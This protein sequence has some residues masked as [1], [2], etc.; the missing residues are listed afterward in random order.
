MDVF[1]AKLIHIAS[2]NLHIWSHTSSALPRCLQWSH[3]L[4]E[5]S[6]DAE[7]RAHFSL[8]LRQFCWR[9][10]E[11]CCEV[12]ALEVKGHAVKNLP[13]T[14]WPRIQ[15]VTSDQTGI[16]QKNW[17]A[18]GLLK[19]SRAYSINFFCSFSYIISTL[20]LFFA[21]FYQ[22]YWTH[23]LWIIIKWGVAHNWI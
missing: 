16:L 1:S 21:Q 8:T 19:Y 14:S 7:Q 11:V 5:F 13:V 4:A 12:R 9:R 23:C 6:D 20:F 18:L 17:D 22:L 2:V 15:A 10:L 3:L